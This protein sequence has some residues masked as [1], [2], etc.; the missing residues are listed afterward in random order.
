MSASARH[1]GQEIRKLTQ[2]HPP[3]YS[4]ADIVNMLVNLIASL[5]VV[6]MLRELLEMDEGFVTLRQLLASVHLIGVQLFA[7]IT[8]RDVNFLTDEGLLLGD[9]AALR[10]ESEKLTKECDEFLLAVWQ[11]HPP[12]GL[13]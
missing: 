10:S 12:R 7:A 4:M 8:E 1:V 11:P 6:R 5:S 2:Q 9:I 13:W 3:E